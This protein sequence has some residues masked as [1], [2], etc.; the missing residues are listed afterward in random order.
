MRW[1]ARVLAALWASAS[2][3]RLA[4]SETEPANVILIMA[5]DIGYEC[6]GAYGSAYYRT[7]R[8]D[9][10]A[11]AGT[12]FDHC[13]SQPL[14]TPSRVKLMTGL[15]NVRNYVGFSIFPQSSRSIGRY[16][17]DQGYATGVFGKWQLYGAEHYGERFRGKGTLPEEAGFERHAL[18][19]VDRLGSRFWGPLLRIDGENRQ[20]G[21]DEYGPSVVADHLLQFI[22]D[23]RVTPFLVYYPMI[24]VHSPFEPTPSSASRLERDKQKNFADMVEM[25]DRIVGQIVDHV[26]ALGLADRTHILFIGDNGTHKNIRS[27]LGARVIQGG[28]GSPTDAG[29][30][31]PL[32]AYGPGHGSTGQVSNVLVEFSDIL[33]TALDLAH[34]PIPDGLDGISFAAALRGEPFEGRESIFIYSNPRPERTQPL[35]FARDRRWKLYGDGRFFDVTRDVMETRPLA[36]P[37]P[38]APSFGPWERLRA[39]LERMPQ[40]GQRLLQLD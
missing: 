7:P 24:L 15:S 14:C 13:Y 37:T 3:L 32:I 26:E 2:I 25:M 1:G 17:Q 16:F 19:Q 4:A 11:A 20:F 8:L 33:P 10:L 12:R 30:R 28:K 27:P 5:D 34:C 36:T 18:W 31:V 29:T 23:H 22:S 38:G 39:T 40:E 35:R 9:A 21:P 6:L